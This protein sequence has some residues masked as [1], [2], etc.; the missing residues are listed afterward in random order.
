MGWMGDESKDTETIKTSRHLLVLQVLMELHEFGLVPHAVRDVEQDA[1]LQRVRRPLQ[2]GPL[3]FL[4]HL[5]VK[6]A[7][8]QV[9]V[10]VVGH[11]VRFQ[12]LLVR[13]LGPPEVAQVERRVPNPQQQLLH[14]AVLALELEL[15]QRQRP[16]V[17]AFPQEFFQRRRPFRPFRRLALRRPRLG[18]HTPHHLAFTSLP[19]SLS[20]LVLP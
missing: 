11:V 12:Q 14:V 8:R 5:L 6:I 3:G 20:F 10:D 7:A 15:Q 17:I 19:T 18:F 13:F 4:V 1:V 16:R 9:Q 2:R